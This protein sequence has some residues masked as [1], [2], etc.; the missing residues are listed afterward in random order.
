MLSDA[1]KKQV[2]PLLMQVPIFSSFDK[3]S[4]ESLANSGAKKTHKSGEVIAKQGEK[5]VTFYLIL[6]G[7]V[8]VRRGAKVLAKLGKGQFFGEMALFD[9]QPRSAD[10]VAK[11]ETTCFVLTSW[12]FA[13]MIAPNPKIAQAV[14]KELVRRLRETD[15]TLSE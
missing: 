10:V 6:D 4:L 14:I 7:S 3:K 5:A 13:G 8:E 11:E 9:E 1:E 12:S 2:I 15:K